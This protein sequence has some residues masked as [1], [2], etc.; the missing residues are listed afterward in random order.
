M[1]NALLIGAL[2]YPV[3]IHQESRDWLLDTR[4]LGLGFRGDGQGEMVLGVPL[5]AGGNAS[6]GIVTSKLA[7]MA[8]ESPD[9]EQG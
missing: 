4:G 2:A 5:W 3:W 7:F 1:R 6:W 8:G 9:E